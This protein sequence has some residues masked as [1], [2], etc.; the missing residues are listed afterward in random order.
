MNYSCMSHVMV[1]AVTVLAN[2]AIDQGFFI[3]AVNGP[4]WAKETVQRAHAAG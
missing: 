2:G 4:K 1:G 3:D